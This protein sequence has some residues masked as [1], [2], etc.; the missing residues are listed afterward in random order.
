MRM[1]RTKITAGSSRTNNQYA[2]IR[3]RRVSKWNHP[4]PSLFIIRSHQIE[5]N[6]K[7]P[8]FP[9]HLTMAPNRGIQYGKI[10]KSFTPLYS[11]EYREITNILHVRRAT[12]DS[13]LIRTGSLRKYFKL[14][15]INWRPQWPR[16]LRRKPCKFER[17]DREFESR[18]R[19]GC[20]SSSFCLRCSVYVEDSARGWSLVQRFLPSI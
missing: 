17:W 8:S 6:E 4:L 14:V 19:H 15:C 7:R 3:S 5:N 12:T 10:K 11:T 1:Q 16:G 2:V 13:I 18:I 20:L 9:Q